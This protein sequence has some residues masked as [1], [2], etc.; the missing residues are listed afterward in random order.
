MEANES[1]DNKIK[2]SEKQLGRAAITCGLTGLVLGGPVVGAAVGI[3]AAIIATKPGKA[4]AVAHIS[5]NI[6]NAA[7]DSNMLG[8]S[9]MWLGEN[10]LG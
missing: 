3:G 7:R 6:I 1:E 8:K 9:I 4:G 5:G 2:L 10:K